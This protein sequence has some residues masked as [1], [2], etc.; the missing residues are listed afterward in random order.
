MYLLFSGEQVITRSDLT[1]IVENHDD[2][3]RI[4]FYKDGTRIITS[5]G[6]WRVEAED[7]APVQVRIMNFKSQTSATFYGNDCFPSLN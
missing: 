7:Y 2:V 3:G 1:M 6:N 4:V 5:K